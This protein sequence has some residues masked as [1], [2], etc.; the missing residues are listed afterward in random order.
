MTAVEESGGRISA[1]GAEMPAELDA[2]VGE[3]SQLQA[4][5]RQEDGQQQHP[6][7]RQRQ[8][9]VQLEPRRRGVRWPWQRQVRWN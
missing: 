3:V 9:G 2:V 7:A 8:A 1:A 5:R 6:R 4:G